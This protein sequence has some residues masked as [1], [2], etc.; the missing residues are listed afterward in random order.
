MPA[1]RGM[2]KSGQLPEGGLSAQVIS[3]LELL[4]RLNLSRSTLDI[5]LR[6][7]AF[8]FVRLSLQSRCYLISSV[9]GWLKQ[10]EV[11]HR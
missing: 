7:K 9:V 11:G 3:E 2:H 4:E 10:H 1:M 5:L 6:E 8:P